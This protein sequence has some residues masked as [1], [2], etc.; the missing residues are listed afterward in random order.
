[1][2]YLKQLHIAVIAIAATA[3][4]LFAMLMP[5]AGT[6]A[7]QQAAP[8]SFFDDFSS[9]TLDPVWQTVAFTGTRV[10]GYTSPA[11]HFSLTDNPGH[12]RYY[13]DPLTHA[14]GFL[15]NYQ[16]IV[17][18][19][20]IW[21]YD[22]GLE[23]H[24]LF[25]GD[26]WLFET[27][28][29]YYLPYTNGRN[30]EARICFGDGGVGTFGV[31]FSR[32][33]DSGGN[34]NGLSIVLFE[35]TGPSIDD[36]PNLESAYAPEDVNGPAESTYFL[37]LERNGGVLTASWS[38]DGVT[39]NTAWRRDMGASL[40]GL[41]QRLVIVGGSWQINAGS[42][43]DYDYVRLMPADPPPTPTP[44][45]T[46]TATPTPTPTPTMTYTPMPADVLFDHLNGADRKSVV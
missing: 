31:A 6:T 24:R 17:D 36:L 14:Q 9:P 37:R 34:V 13:L 19:S 5:L 3:V 18:S 33:R 21:S 46:P 12:L 2:N 26:H 10:N 25:G 1:M 43:A 39:W 20:S 38:A 28:A 4:V 45:T 40:T 32:G 15:N 16:T 35:K 41:Q 7:A 27:K 29:D 22:P 8:T 30:L 11:N 44:T 42:Y 23:L